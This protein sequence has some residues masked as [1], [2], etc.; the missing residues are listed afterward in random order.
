[1]LRPALTP[2]QPAWWLWSATLALLLA[3]LAGREA[4]FPAALALSLAQ[5]GHAAWRH[6]GGLALAVQIRLAYS[7]LLALGLL[8]GLDWLYWLP[9]A[10]TLAL[11]LFGYCLLARTLSLLPWHRYEPLTPGLL[12]RTFLSRPVHLRLPAGSNPSACGGPGGVC[13]LEARAA[14]V[15]PPPRAW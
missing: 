1:M 15:A 6:R 8:P 4:A 12:R 7:G 11:L 3:G 14:S 13:E 10:G 5:T 9:A 2:D